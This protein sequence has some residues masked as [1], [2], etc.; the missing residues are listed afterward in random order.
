MFGGYYDSCLWRMQCLVAIIMTA[1]CGE[2]S[3]VSDV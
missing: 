1:A 2:C 3:V